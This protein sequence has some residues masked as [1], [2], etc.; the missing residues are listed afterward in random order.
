ML[1]AGIV[2]SPI[3]AKARAVRRCGWQSNWARGRSAM[4]YAI[5]GIALLGG[6]LLVANV[7]INADPAKLGR[8]VG[9]FVMG[10]GVAGA[11][12]LLIGLIA[13]E[14][15]GP[16][17]AVAGGLAP[18]VIRGRT[19]WRRHHGGASTAGSGQMSEVETDLLRMKLDHDSGAMSGQVRRGPYAGR[20][21]EDLDQGELIGLW[22][23]CVAE[24]ESGARLLETYL[25]RL[26]PDWRQAGSGGAGGGAAGPS[27]DVMTREQAYAIL[28][29][30]PGA[31]GEDVKEAHRRL[32]MK[33]HPDHGG[34]TFLAAQINR[35]K[36]FL[37]GE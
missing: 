24:D 12:A 16:A 4:I 7:L 26:R 5:L 28:D 19:L 11:G 35:A 9:W 27:S 30:E 32:M 13:S 23:Q 22:R 14:R 8:T 10:L 6:L 25:D 33:L 17:L 15:L 20:R 18:I 34:S 2:R 37:L 31:S 29:L 21:I 1:P 36:D 3:T